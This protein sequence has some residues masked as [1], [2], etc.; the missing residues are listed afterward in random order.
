MSDIFESM[1]K[2]YSLPINSQFRPEG[3]N[4]KTWHRNTEKYGI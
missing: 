4:D 2:P 3:P 1:E